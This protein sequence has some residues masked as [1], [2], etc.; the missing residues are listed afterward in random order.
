[1]TPMQL[2][3]DAVIRESEADGNFWSTL[4]WTSPNVLWCHNSSLE[5]PLTVGN[6]QSIAFV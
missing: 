1:M 2:Q 3:T 6:G 4:Y 5:W